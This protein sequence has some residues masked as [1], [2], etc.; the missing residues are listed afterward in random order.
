MLDKIDIKLIKELQKNCELVL[1]E[2]SKRVGL[3]VT[4]VNE[5][6]KKLRSNIVI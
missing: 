3:S 5:R 6:L 2:L 4:P 1:H